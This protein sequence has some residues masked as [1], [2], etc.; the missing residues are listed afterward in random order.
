MSQNSSAAVVIGALRD[1]QPV[2]TLKGP[3][4]YT[5][6]LQR[7]KLQSDMKKS[8]TRAEHM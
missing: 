1:N 5:D 6:A 8:M 7:I 2:Q 4:A 3:S